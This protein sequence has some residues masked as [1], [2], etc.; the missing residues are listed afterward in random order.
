MQIRGRR[1]YLLGSV[2]FANP[3]SRLSSVLHV[4]CSRASHDSRPRS[5]SPQ[6][7]LAEP[8]RPGRVSALSSGCSGESLRSS[9]LSYPRLLCSL[10]PRGQE[11]IP[12]V[13]WGPRLP[14][15]YCNLP[16]GSA[17]ST[18]HSFS[19]FTVLE[20]FWIHE[21]CLLVCSL[22]VAELFN[23]KDQK[24]R[25]KHHTL[26]M[27]VGRSGAWPASEAPEQQADG[28]FCC[29]NKEHPSSLAQPAQT[30]QRTP[31]QGTKP[32]VQLWRGSQEHPAAFAGAALQS[33]WSEGTMPLGRKQEEAAKENSVSLSL[34]I[35]SP[36]QHGPR[37]P[38]SLLAVIL[39]NC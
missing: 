32:G 3:L 22:P 31:G 4:S 8:C 35:N 38:P 28:T 36:L 7:A 34:Q 24:V 23:R 18:P 15:I 10:F 20:S 12:A 21:L 37:A 14:G 29:W 30:R 5:P 9:E 39:S 2:H 19:I 33:Q 17:S 27:A 25:E 26:G 6:G 13:A 1:I 11:G 16:Q